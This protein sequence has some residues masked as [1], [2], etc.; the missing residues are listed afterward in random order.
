MLW[1]RI[2]D[3]KTLVILDDVSRRIDLE[4]VGLVHVRSCNLLLTSRYKE[5][6]FSETGTRKNFLLDLLC[7]QE[8]WSLFEKRAGAVIKDDRIQ[9]VANELAKKCGGLPILVVAVASGLR[10]RSLEEW[11][12]TL[13][14]FKNFEKKTIDRN[15]ILDNRVE[16][17]S[18]G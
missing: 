17:Q 13:R 15:S 11:K 12:D 2:K 7:E 14:R 8:S 1:R 10:E 3:K 18:I 4:A 16:L 6:L 5:V 9:R